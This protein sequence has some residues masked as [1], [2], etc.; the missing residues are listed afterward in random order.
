MKKLLF[1][2]LF[3]LCAFGE[4]YVK[5]GD[6]QYAIGNFVK[7]IQFYNKALSLNTK[8][9]KAY[10]GRG[11]VHHELKDYSSAVNDYTNAIAIQPN[12]L[13]III[14]RGVSYSHLGDYKN[15]TKDARKACE[16]GDCELFGMLKQNGML[17][18]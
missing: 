11:I 10:N 6:K 9:V 17:I 4:D 16:L 8:N 18:D 3:S 15:A 5:Q 1:I 2:L 7:A 14:N 13:G 12:N